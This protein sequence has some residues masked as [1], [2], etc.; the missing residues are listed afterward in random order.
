MQYRPNTKIPCLTYSELIPKIMTAENYRQMKVRGSLTATCTGGNGRVILIEYPSLP[1]KY[2]RAVVDEYGDPYAIVAGEVAAEPLKELVV[3]D[4]AAR[5]FYTEEYLL[6]NREPLPLHYQLKYA[7]QCDW[8][9]AIKKALTNKGATKELLNISIDQ[10]WDRFSLLINKDDWRF[11]M[12]QDGKMEKL[13][14]DLPSSVGRLQR[15]Y[16]L[17]RDGGYAG[18]VEAWRFGNDYARKVTPK[19]ENL[20][21]SL[22]CM[23]HKPYMAEVCKMYREFIAGKL[24]VVDVHPHGGGEIFDPRDFYIQKKGQRK[25]A[26]KG[27]AVLTI[28]YKLGESTVD[29]YLKQPKNEAIVNKLRM[30]QLD[31]NTAHRPSV[32]RLPPKCSFSKIT[33]DDLDIPFKTPDGDRAVKSYQVFDVA[34]GAVIGVSFSRDKNVEL[35][36]EALRDMFRLIML[37]GWGVP[38]E[39][40]F[41][42]HLTSVMTGGKNEDGTEYDDILTAGTVFPATRMCIGGNAKEKRAEGFIRVKKYG[43][44]KKRPGFQARFYA[45]LLTNRLNPDQDKVRYQYNEIVQNEIDDIAAHNNELHPNKEL[46][47]NMTRWEVLEQSQ[48][49]NLPKYEPRQVIQYIG[50]R[51]RVTSIKAGKLQVQG[52]EY[53]LPDMHLIGEQHYNGEILAYYIPDE[54]GDIA[55][56]YVFEDGQYLCEA[57]KKVGFQEAIIEQTAED[58]KI[59]QEQWGQQSQFD[60]MIKH[61]GLQHIDKKTGKNVGLIPVVGVTKALPE[62][63]KEVMVVGTEASFNFDQD[64]RPNEDE[65]T[66]MSVLVQQA[67]S[68]ANSM[69]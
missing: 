32:K 1:K 29:Y 27:T 13:G 69:L 46:Y 54:G 41:E 11:E 22:Y 51:S 9:G 33:M 61:A 4:V 52:C 68:R 47:P 48:N 20:I 64:D 44:Q 14:H 30:K 31:Y 58:V 37:K 63:T 35:I 25:A 40:E 42:K 5:R 50:H 45:R 10:L 57:K 60:A 38:F 65:Y 18:I 24:Q 26:E 53:M 7:R 36:R 19:I 3:V 59:M 23:P 8:F 62:P 15:R 17:F 28:P 6:P 34:S 56:V 49:P 2:Q 39:I 16:R 12:E 67:K 43:Q 21:V 66:D 55:S